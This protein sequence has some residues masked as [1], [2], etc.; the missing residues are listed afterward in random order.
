[1]RH[2]LADTVRGFFADW[3]LPRQ[4]AGESSQS[5]AAES[6]M[7][8]AA[9]ALE[10]ADKVGT[11]ICPYCAVGCA[12]LIY[13]KNG[14][15]HPH[16]GRPAQPD[17]PGHALPEGRGDL[18]LLTSPTSASTTVIYRAPYS[19]RWE[20]KPLDWAMDRIAQLVKQT[21]DETFVTE[22]AGRHAGQPHA[23]DRLARRRHARQR[24]ELP[25]Q[26]AVR[27]RPRHGVDRKPGP[28]MTQLLGAQSGRHVR[29]WSRDHRRNGTSPTRTASW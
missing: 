14:E 22:P 21:R 18:R 15:G 13:A 5:K 20:R 19:D 16:R 17:Q 4:M 11:S 9:A 28:S 27:R 23:G 7:S 8:R 3:S 25:D 2:G 1:M 24:R 12:Q 6:T 26:E 29:P 10:E